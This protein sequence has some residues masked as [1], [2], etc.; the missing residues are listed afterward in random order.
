MNLTQH[1]HCTHIIFSSSFSCEV[2]VYIYHKWTCS[3]ALY[4]QR[5][6]CIFVVKSMWF[7]TQLV[8]ALGTLDAL[9]PQRNWHSSSNGIRTAPGLSF[10]H[11]STFRCWCKVRVCEGRQGTR[12]SKINCLNSSFIFCVAVVWVRRDKSL[13]FWSVSTEMCEKHLAGFFHIAPGA[14]CFAAGLE[15]N[16]YFLSLFKLAKICGAGGKK[17]KKKG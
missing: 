12:V 7:H 10:Q 15:S 17:K 6:D 2:H 9:L 11:L 5:A 1:I 16:F 14:R 13:G 3:V 4:Y 8:S